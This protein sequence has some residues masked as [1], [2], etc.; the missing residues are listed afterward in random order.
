MPTSVPAD[1][2]QP[3]NNSDENVIFNNQVIQ[4]D[5]FLQNMVNTAF[6]QRM[7]SSGTNV[8]Y[9]GT[10]LQGMRSN[11]SANEMS[12]TPNNHTGELEVIDLCDEQ[13]QPEVHP[14]T[15]NSNQNNW[16]QAPS[17]HNTSGNDNVVVAQRQHPSQPPMCIHELKNSTTVKSND[18]N[19]YLGAATSSTTAT[20]SAPGGSFSKI[21]MNSNNIQA[22]YSVQHIQENSFSSTFGPLMNVNAVN[23]GTSVKKELSLNAFGMPTKRNVSGNV[24]VNSYVNPT[25]TTETNR[26]SSSKPPVLINNSTS[27]PHPSVVSN[28]QN[29]RSPLGGSGQYSSKQSSNSNAADRI[30]TNTTTLPRQAHVARNSPGKAPSSSGVNQKRKPDFTPSQPLCDPSLTKFVK[31]DNVP[32]VTPLLSLNPAQIHELET[33]LQFTDENNNRIDGWKDDWGG[34]LQLLEKEIITNRDK[35]SESPHIKPI[36]KVFKEVVCSKAKGGN[37]GA[38]RGILLLFSFVY[39]LKDTPKMAKKLL[40]Y[41]LVKH[42]E[43][44]LGRAEFIA[45]CI[46]RIS[47][48]PTVLQEDGWTTVKAEK[49]EGATG[50]AYLIGRRVI[51]SCFEAVVIAFV[52]DDGLGDLWK[53][54]WIEDLETFDLEADEI[55]DAMRKYD[56]KIARKKAKLEKKMSS[57]GS[58]S[59]SASKDSSIESKK[60]SNSSTRFSATINFTVENIE[61]GIILATSYDENARYGVLW[62][63]RVLHVSELNAFSKSGLTSKRSSQKNN[64]PVM[65]LAPYWNGGATKVK[66]ENYEKAKRMFSSGPLFALEN[67]EVSNKN[68]QKYPYGADSDSLSIDKLRDSFRFLGLPKAAFSRYVDSHRLAQSLK[69]YARCHLSETSHASNASAALTETHVLSVQTAMFP[70]IVLN[71]PYDYMLSKLPHPDQQLSQVSRD[72]TEE[73][74]EPVLQLAFITKTMTPPMCWGKGIPNHETKSGIPKNH[75]SSML[76]TPTKSRPFTPVTSPEARESMSISCLKSGN[77]GKVT[78]SHWSVTDFASEYLLAFLEHENHA[79]NTSVSCLSLQ[80]TNLVKRLCRDMSAALSKNTS[81]RKSMLNSISNHCLLVKVRLV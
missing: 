74:C 7:A 78:E 60:P 17:P 59:I 38:F 1:Y 70:N 51:W 53:A 30:Q 67:I 19:D 73:D 39:H 32:E 64:V 48:D 76:G 24:N 2:G 62:P 80:L 13:S 41:S 23:N 66:Y 35:L 46:R 49:P 75:E 4:R 36:T 42:V 6:H 77:A 47:Y 61:H 21:H 56:A 33:M 45:A 63:A 11:I 10:L 37:A 69:H 34:N 71:L 52:R 65:F 68:I 79:E 12:T 27:R 3:S 55:Q 5:V 8:Q 9:P 44:A 22:P 50:G 31:L 29:T 43:N 54:M 16:M 18:G 40:A 15:S 20:L 25:N 72:D 28:M 14:S 57:S 26:S 81:E 58:S